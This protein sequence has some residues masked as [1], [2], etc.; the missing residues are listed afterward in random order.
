MWP[1]PKKNEDKK[2]NN[3]DKKKNNEDK[4]KMS[5]FF[6]GRGRGHADHEGQELTISNIRS[7]FLS[8]DPILF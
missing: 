4:K 1:P 5:I 6:E 8:C 7:I 2:K 3:E